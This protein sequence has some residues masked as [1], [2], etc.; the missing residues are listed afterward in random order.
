MPN[1]VG[2]FLC[3]ATDLTTVA[4]SYTCPNRLSFAV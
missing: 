2:L 1:R 4:T 3:L